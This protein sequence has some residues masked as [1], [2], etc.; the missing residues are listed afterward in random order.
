MLAPDTWRR[1]VVTLDV[2]GQQ[3]INVRTAVA[4]LPPVSNARES[5]AKAVEAF[6]YYC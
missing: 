1:V 5:E 3:C 2:L 4:H 6:Q